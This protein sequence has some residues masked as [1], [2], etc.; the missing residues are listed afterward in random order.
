M[1]KRRTALEAEHTRAEIRTRL[2]RERRSSYL[3]DAVLGAIDGCVT[4]FAVVAGAAGANLPRSVAIILGFAN[5]LA[6][7]FSMAVSN[8]QRNQSDR[9]RIEQARRSE[10]GHIAEIPE[11][12]RREIH[13][14]FRRKGFHG[15]MLDEIVHVI[16]RNR[17]R[18]VDTMLTEEMGLRLVAPVPWR[19]AVVTFLAFGVAGLIPLLPLLLPEAIAPAQRLPSSIVATGGAFLAIG[20]LKGHVLGRPRLRAGLETLL[21]GG[22]AA[23]LAYLAGLLLGR[24]V[25]TV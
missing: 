23:A 2:A 25:G 4:T 3:G 17:R 24:L 16:T 13:E 7:G 12:E 22:V 20:L 15:E 18:W 6:D 10:E 11:G 9:E 8:Y 1:G 14:I 5:L 21:V 19:A